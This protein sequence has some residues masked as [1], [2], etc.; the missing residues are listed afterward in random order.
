VAR[1]EAGGKRVFQEALYEADE[2]GRL[3]PVLPS[4][5]AFAEG[6]GPCRL[7]IDHVR[8]RKTGPRFPLA[9]VGCRDHP[10]G[11]YTLYPPGHH[12]YGREAI[13][14]CSPSGELQVEASTGEPLWEATLF[15]AAQDAAAGRR[16]PEDSPWDDSRRRRTQG[17]WLDFAGRLLGVHPGQDERIRE[18]IALRLG[19]PLV[20]LLD[21]ARGWGVGWRTRG[22]VILAVLLMIEPGGLLLDRLL[23]AGAVADLWPEPRRAAA[24]PGRQIAVRSGAPERTPLRV[25]RSRGPPPTNLQPPSVH[26][27]T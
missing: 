16:W 18:R 3:R 21:Q 11:R 8:P 1:A 13:V 17:R 2:R 15:R 9:V 22:A 7:Y 27:G 4:R 23:K 19:V 10:H 26:S 14:P 24:L 20:R 5:C 12:P 6:P 25:P